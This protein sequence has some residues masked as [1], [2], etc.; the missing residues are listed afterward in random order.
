MGA[1][2][3]DGSNSPRGFARNG[4]LPKEA[5]KAQIA[6]PTVASVG[7]PK[8]CR[9]P[10]GFGKFDPARMAAAATQLQQQVRSLSAHIPP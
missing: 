8:V 6:A 7:S 2:S 5:E 1:G 3:D 10:Q 9:Q 4:S